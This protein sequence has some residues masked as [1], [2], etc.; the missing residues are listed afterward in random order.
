MMHCGEYLTLDE[1]FVK[2]I[3]NIGEHIPD[4]HIPR[5]EALPHTSKNPKKPSGVGCEF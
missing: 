2:I 3:Q 4:A 5:G 1:A